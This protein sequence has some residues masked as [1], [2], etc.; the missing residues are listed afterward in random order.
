MIIRRAFLVG[1]F[2][3]VAFAANNLTGTWKLNV[4][5]SKY[6]GIPAPK[7]VTVTYSPSGAGWKYEAKG[8]SADGKPSIITFSYSKDDTDMPM[9]GYPYA[10]T[11]SLKGGNTDS[12][13]GIFK[14]AGKQIGTA[15]RTISK[16]G[17]TMTV[18][19][20]LTL[21]DGKKASYMTIYEKQ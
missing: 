18:N 7:E 15:D 11:L 8:T 13:T 6:T 3:L 9:T 10:D 5:K 19:A 4:A 14:R 20:T 2:A 21:P 17:K 12:S 1:A 16:D